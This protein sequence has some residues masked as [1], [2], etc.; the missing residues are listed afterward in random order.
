MNTPHKIYHEY[1]TQLALL[2]RL[3]D[4]FEKYEVPDEFRDAIINE[5]S[6]Q[7]EV[8]TDGA[9]MPTK[10]HGSIDSF[11]KAYLDANMTDTIRT[12]IKKGKVFAQLV[13]HAKAGDMKKYRACRVEYSSL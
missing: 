2:P 9:V 11:V 4:A 1:E 6:K 7:F 3:N 13:E 8:Y 12:R 5:S 10:G